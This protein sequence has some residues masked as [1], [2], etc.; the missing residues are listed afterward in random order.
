MAHAFYGFGSSPTCELRQAGILVLS[1]KPTHPAS[2]AIAQPSPQELIL[3]GRWT[4]HGVG[5]AARAMDTLRLPV[6]GEI[7]VDAEQ[8]IALDS[9]GALVLHKFMKGLRD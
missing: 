7:I 6:S 8:I 2:A 1:M 4:V 9:A 5:A 3:S